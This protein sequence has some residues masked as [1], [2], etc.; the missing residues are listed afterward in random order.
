M[1]GAK[2]D[3]VIAVPGLGVLPKFDGGA[4]AAV[5]VGGTVAA[6]AGFMTLAWVV[7]HFV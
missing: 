5:M 6:T 2:D 1:G 7:G 3:L 4:R